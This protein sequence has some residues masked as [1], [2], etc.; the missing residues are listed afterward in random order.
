MVWKVGHEVCVSCRIEHLKFWNWVVVRYTAETDKEGESICLRRYHM[1]RT[2]VAAWAKPKHGNN[3]VTLFLHFNPVQWIREFAILIRLLSG[4]QHCRMLEPSVGAGGNVFGWMGKDHKEALEEETCSAETKAVEIQQ[5]QS[6]FGWMGK[7]HKEALEEETC[8]AETK[9]VEI[10]QLQSSYL[11]V[12][13][14]RSIYL[15]IEHILS[16]VLESN[17]AGEYFPESKTTGDTRVS[18]I[19]LLILEKVDDV[20]RLHIPSLLLGSLD[21]P[22]NL[23]IQASLDLITAHKFCYIEQSQKDKI[24]LKGQIICTGCNNLLNRV[25]GLLLKPFTHGL[26]KIWRVFFFQKKRN[27]KKSD[28]MGLAKSVI[29]HNNPFPRRSVVDATFF[30]VDFYWLVCM[31]FHSNGGFND[32]S[33]VRIMSMRLVLPSSETPCTSSKTE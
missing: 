32:P 1:D 15:K 23:E 21:F 30:I 19:L 11:V 10:Q 5:L 12:V 29:C 28:L 14:S 4:L 33:L 18:L 7:D 9:A 26:Y 17:K 20:F 25:K 3:E 16:T 31:G 8:S 13:D 24:T 27:S 2:G 6:S 22:F